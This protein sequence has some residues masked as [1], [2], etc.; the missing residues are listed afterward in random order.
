MQM[1]ICYF[2]TYEEDYPRN[3]LLIAGLRESGA[4]VYECHESIWRGKRDKSKAYRGL[5][6]FILVFRVL[7]AYFRLTIRYFQLPNHDLVIVGYVG[8]LD[9]LL[10]WL[11]TR[12]RGF[13]LV[14]NPMLSL[15]DTFCADRALVP[16][17]SFTGRIL[18]Q[19]D[20][21]ACQA[22]DLIL[23]D[24]QAHL[25][26][27]TQTFQLPPTKF[28]V[29]P[30]GADDR[31]FKP[32]E[33]VT[34]SKKEFCEV[35]FVGK[36][37]PLH[38]CKTIIQ[39]AEELR[40]E[41]IH[42]TLIGLGQEQ[43]EIKRLVTEKHLKNVT[44]IDW[45]A[46]EALPAQYA[47]ADLCLGIFGETAKAQRVVPNKVYQA[48][49]MGKPV[50]TADT[51]ALRAELALG[52]EIWV[53]KPADSLDLAAQIRK[54][55]NDS[56][57]RQQLAQNGL[58]AF[59]QRYRLAVLG[60]NVYQH[61][62]EQIPGFVPESQMIWG[63]Q[64][65]L[66][67]PRHRFREDY[68]LRAVQTYA[69]GK[70]VLDVG[71]GAGSMLQR[72]AKAGYQPFGLDMA[73][74]FLIYLQQKLQNTQI[75]LLKG[76][77]F[78]LPW[79]NNKFDAVVISEVLEHIEDD[80]AALREIWRVLRPGGVCVL[81]VPADPE[82]YDWFDRW[83]GHLRRYQKT[84]LQQRLESQGFTVKSIHFF[85]FPLVRLFHQFVYLPYLRKALKKPQQKRLVLQ[86]WR[87]YFVG[88]LIWL[89]FHLDQLFD[90]SPLGIGLIAVAQKPF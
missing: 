58:N 59:Q 39:A 51:P 28:R 19:L 90:E 44:L 10:A 80:E 52:K 70:R 69:P 60:N 17:Q 56:G 50:L 33:V 76:D 43:P 37:I 35:L 20:Y 61:L 68:L 46:Y 81:S 47:Q 42:F 83:V 22:A 30:I 78:Q 24:T 87:K 72:L 73:L 21:W 67:G 38:G 63:S 53:C 88:E 16:M 32:N 18:W 89:L 13:S 25:D 1:R 27:F 86:T 26:Y 54:L 57:L 45:V 2:G 9:M 29:V 36:F 14:F 66:Y 79:A 4:I 7:I 5:T 85:G 62:S 64:P 55:A 77:L 23:L 15:F 74:P 75:S 31:L 49:A 40:D 41:P 82:Q 11:L 84:E 34:N 8:Q 12:L 65:E 71:C 48:L 6:A 3:A